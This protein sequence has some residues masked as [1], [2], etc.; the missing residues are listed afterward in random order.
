MDKH[1]FTEIEIKFEQND[2]KKRTKIKEIYDNELKSTCF[3][4][5]YL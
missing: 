5:C 4:C 2:E 3:I 1:I